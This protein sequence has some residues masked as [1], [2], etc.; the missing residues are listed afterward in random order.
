MV[1]YDNRKTPE[2]IT[3]AGDSILNKL[4]GIGSIVLLVLL[5]VLMVG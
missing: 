5:L 1:Q 3:A 4:V 2:E